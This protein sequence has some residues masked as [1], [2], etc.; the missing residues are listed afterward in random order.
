MLI[1][2]EKKDTKFLGKKVPQL[3][4]LSGKG[5]VGKTSCASGLAYTLAQQNQKVL[6]ISTDPAHSIGDS[7][8]TELNPGIM[9]RYDEKLSL[10]LLELAFK[11]EKKNKKSNFFAE[12]LFPSSEEFIILTELGLILTNLIKTKNIF[13]FVVID[14]APS[15][16]SMRLLQFPNKLKNYIKKIDEVGNRLKKIENTSAKSDNT[17]PNLKNKTIINRLKVFIKVL[18]NPNVSQFILVGIPET[19]SYL[20]SKRF[21]ELIQKLDIPCNN[22]ILNKLESFN[23]VNNSHCKFCTKRRQNQKEIVQKIKKEFKDLNIT[24]IKLFSME[25][26]GADSLGKMN[27]LDLSSF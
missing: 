2:I 27:L 26:N 25:M 17:K 15:G 22:Y 12:L 13:D 7:L 14:M 24:E 16:H 19:L 1:N 6:L 11:P 8:K 5:G 9:T 4:F 18:K 3:I 21:Y 23:D 10:Y 20:E